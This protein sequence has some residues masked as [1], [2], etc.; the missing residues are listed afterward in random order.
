MMSAF[1]KIPLQALV[2]TGVLV[3]VFYLFQQPPM[4]F[5]RVHAE[6]RGQR[7]RRRVPAPRS[8]FETAF[9][10]R[11]TAAASLAEADAATRP[12][13][14]RPSAPPTRR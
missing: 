9:A 10:A 12:A 7:S 6:N 1:V 4:L 14:R 8:E 5:N 13:P 3:F 2:L 11:R